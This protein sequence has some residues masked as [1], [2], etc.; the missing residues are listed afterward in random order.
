LV[1]QGAY[2]VL[3]EIG[4]LGYP[5]AKAAALALLAQTGVAGIPG[6]A[7][8]Q[9]RAGDSLLRFCFAKNDETLAEAAR[10]LRR[11]RPA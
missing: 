11:F 1:P 10:R 8:F 7:F 2:Y 3:A 9:G 6:T 5:D 4:H